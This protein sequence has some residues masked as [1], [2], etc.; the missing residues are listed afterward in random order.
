MQALAVKVFAQ[1]IEGMNEDGTVN[2]G[3]LEP[4][5]VD[6]WVKPVEV[7]HPMAEG[8]GFWL[9]PD[10][11]PVE[12]HEVAHQFETP[13]DTSHLVTVI[14]T[15]M[16]VEV[17]NYTETIEPRLRA[18]GWYL[19]DHHEVI[20]TPEDEANV[21]LA[22]MLDY[23]LR[24]QP[25]EGAPNTIFPP[26]FMAMVTGECP[27]DTT[28]MFLDI[29]AGLAYAISD[30]VEQRGDWATN[31]VKTFVYMVVHGGL[32]EE[33]FAFLVNGHEW[34]RSRINEIKEAM[35]F[36]QSIVEQYMERA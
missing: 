17:I 20:A 26:T 33:Q 24:H 13:E 12:V 21:V 31:P 14:S 19:D 10:L 27:V 29:F 30:D 15:C 35:K 28:R 5:W 23:A 11:D 36:V 16:M 32:S 3:D 1:A 18:A 7:E 4:S 8:D 2:V 34:D 22:P 9:A 25:D 6:S